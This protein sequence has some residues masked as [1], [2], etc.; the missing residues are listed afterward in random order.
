MVCSHGHT[1]GDLHF[2]F[3]FEHV[4]CSVLPAPGSP[5]RRVSHAREPT[6]PRSQHVTIRETSSRCSFRFDASRT[7]SSYIE[8]YGLCPLCDS[9]TAAASSPSGSSARIPFPAGATCRAAQHRATCSTKT[10][11]RWGGAARGRGASFE[12][13]RGRCLFFLFTIYGSLWTTRSTL[14]VWPLFCRHLTP[15]WPAVPPRGLRPGA[16]PPPAPWRRAA[17]DS[18]APRA[19]A[20][21]SRPAGGRSP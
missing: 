1:H 8:L 10:A 15:S 21:R 7:S 13:S 16:G 17:R 4:E 12:L 20:P 9:M 6:Q 3:V 14:W 18:R 5:G 11:C 19:A 2:E